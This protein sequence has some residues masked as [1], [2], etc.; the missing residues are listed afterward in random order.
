MAGSFPKG[1]LNHEL[2]R[3]DRH[4]VHAA[5]HSQPNPRDQPSAAKHLSAKHL[6]AKHLSAK[7]AV[8]D[9]PKEQGILIRTGASRPIVTCR[10]TELARQRAGHP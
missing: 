10:V 9:K 1:I 5:K 2:S 4:A 6:S 3:L 8:Q 7:H